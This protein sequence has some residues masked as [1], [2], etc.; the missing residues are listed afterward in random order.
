M[1]LREYINVVVHRK[2]AIIAVVL[3]VMAAAFVFSLLKNPLY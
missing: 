3:V 1:E 2:W